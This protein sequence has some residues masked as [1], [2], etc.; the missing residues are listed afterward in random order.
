MTHIPLSRPDNTPCGPLREKGMIQRG[1][2]PGYQNTL[3]AEASN[4]L[5]TSIKPVAIFRYILTCYRLITSILTSAPL[6]W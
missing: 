3:S 2:G 4:F 5:L 1:A 6:Q